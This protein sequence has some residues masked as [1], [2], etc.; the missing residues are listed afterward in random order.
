VGKRTTGIVRWFDGSKG[1]GY[2]DAI[3][4]EDVF[5]H[6]S[7]L[8]ENEKPF[9]L[10]GDEVTFFLEQTVRGLQATNVVHLN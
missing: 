10:A 9:L 8:S 7:E 1:Y 4:G 5:V 2:I 3:D 6:Y